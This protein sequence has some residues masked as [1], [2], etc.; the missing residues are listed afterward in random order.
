[1]PPLF[2]NT[3]ASVDESNIPELHATNV[4]FTLKHSYYD[5]PNSK[6]IGD[7]MQKEIDEVKENK[8]QLSEAQINDKE[9]VRNNFPNS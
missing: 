8:G 1:M 7:E 6:G 5:L 3:D 4:S 9:R 2:I